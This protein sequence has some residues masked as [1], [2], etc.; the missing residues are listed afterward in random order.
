MKKLVL[1][2]GL[3]A[4]AA[5]A[6]WR[7]SAADNP[8]AEQVK[9]AE[10]VWQANDYDGSDKV[11]DEAM[12][13]CPNLAELYWRKARNEYDR[14]EDIPRDK[15]PSKDELIKRYRGIEALAAKCTEL[16]PNNGDCFLWKGI[17]MGRRGTTQGILNSLTEAADLEKAF[18]KAIELKPQYR[19]Q[20]GAANSLGDAYNALGQFYRVV[21]EWLCVFG[22]RQLIGTC[23][24]LDKSVEYQR[25]AVAREPKRIEYQKEL[26]ISLICEG[27]KRDQPQDVEEGKKILNDL[28]SLPEFKKTDKIDKQHAK[29]ILANPSL[30]CG[31]SRDAQQEQSKDAY[32]GP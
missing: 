3:L 2:T 24:D 1:V 9:Q 12:K 6:G 19:S 21:P 13:T 30:A 14:I 11:L 22:L 31:Y 15:K 28:Q 7:L 26:G 23:G 32:K 16:E 29:D 27:Q 20:N 17:G 5:I 4:V 25:K 8:C 10:Q 18:L